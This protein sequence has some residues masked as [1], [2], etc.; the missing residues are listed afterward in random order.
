MLSTGSRAR[1]LYKRIW[2]TKGIK[3]TRRNLVLSSLLTAIKGMAKN[4]I[5]HESF[6]SGPIREFR[7][8]DIFE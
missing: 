1:A 5:R 8:S 6:R 7:A 2:V 4:I 3:Q